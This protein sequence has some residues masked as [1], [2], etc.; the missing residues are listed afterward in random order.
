MPFYNFIDYSNQAE[1]LLGPSCGFVFVH[2][3]DP[4]FH[5]FEMAVF[6][7]LCTIA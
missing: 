6:Y 2:R 5:E 3:K 7:E 4:S 1:L